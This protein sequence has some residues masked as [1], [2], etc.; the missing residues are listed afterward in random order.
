MGLVRG[1]ESERDRTES[2]RQQ[3]ERRT[4]LVGDN[5]WM[6]LEWLDKAAGQGRM[7]EFH[8]RNAEQECKYQFRHGPLFQIVYLADA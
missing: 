3:A 2:D 7:K 5:R 4:L 1:L 8:G 6:A